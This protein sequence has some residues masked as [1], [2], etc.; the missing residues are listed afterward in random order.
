M[1]YKAPK[2]RLIRCIGVCRIFSPDSP[3]EEIESDKKTHIFFQ[4]EGD[5]W[6]LMV[7]QVT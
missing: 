7:S 1:A 6:M 4:P 3:C 5:I 2:K